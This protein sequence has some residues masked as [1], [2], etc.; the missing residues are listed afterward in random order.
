MEA[1]HILE[2][3]RLWLKPVSTSNA[4][5]VLEMYNSPKFIQFI[6]DRNIRTVE[7]AENYI[8]EKFLP[9]WEKLGYGNFVIE[10]KEDGKTIGA[11]GI[12][13]REGL[14]VGDIGFSFLPQFQGKG[15]GFEAASKLLEK[16]F[17]DFGLTKVS[18]ITTEENE[19]SRKLILKLGLKYFKKIRLP[20]EQVDLLYFEIEKP[21]Q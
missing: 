8:T 12:F 3:D 2:T 20:E 19:V 5:F 15:Y 10:R 4:A 21:Q 6:G 7:D 17:A 13:Q 11:V 16:A 9:Q 18:A 14:D 1:L